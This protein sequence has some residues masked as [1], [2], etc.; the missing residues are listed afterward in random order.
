LTCRTYSG[1]K[2]LAMEVANFCVEDD[3]FETGLR[4]LCETI[5]ANSRLSHCT[6]NRLIIDT[7][8]LPLAAGLA[9]E[10]YRQ[11]AVGPD[12]RERIAHFI[13]KSRSK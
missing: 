13:T 3:G 1:A 8:G 5:L 7:D 12:M 4:A 6:N 10:V 9:H 11:P 2:A